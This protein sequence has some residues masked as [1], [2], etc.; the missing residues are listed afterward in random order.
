MTC[1]K[2]RNEV[3]NDSKFCCNCGNNLTED[4]INGAG[5]F[6]NNNNQENINQNNQLLNY[7]QS[8]SIN[9]SNS[10]NSKNGLAIAS[11]V[12][13][14]VSLILSLFVNI[15]VFP[16]AVIGL[17]LGLSNRNKCGIR[18]AGIILNI[19][20]LV[21]SLLILILLIWVV[22]SFNSVFVY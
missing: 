1:S 17:V 15:F 6:W 2:C 11:L 4:S 20:S 14:I 5:C 18:M 16:L 22:V 8:L 13:G 3:E 19:I 9:D 12:I 10:Q 21:I 7:Q